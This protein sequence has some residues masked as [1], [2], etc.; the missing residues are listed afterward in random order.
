MRIDE[1]GRKGASTQIDGFV[2]FVEKPRAMRHIT[3]SDDCAVFYGD[4]FSRRLR[5]IHR[6]DIP[7]IIQLF[8]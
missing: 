1:S 8:V 2:S 5:I 7:V 6:Y 3:D 4:R